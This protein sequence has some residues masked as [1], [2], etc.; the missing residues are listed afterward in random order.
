MTTHDQINEILK[1]V[2]V[3]ASDNGLPTFQCDSWQHTDHTWHAHVSYLRAPL[4]WVRFTVQGGNTQASVL[5][6]ALAALEAMTSTAK[7][8]QVNGTLV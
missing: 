8:E 5:R 4:K 3:P 1:R 6:V 7:K 2:A